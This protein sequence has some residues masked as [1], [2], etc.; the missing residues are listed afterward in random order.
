MKRT[1]K[2]TVCY[3]TL[4]LGFAHWATAEEPE[5]DNILVIGQSGALQ[6]SLQQ[7][8]DADNLMTVSTSDAIGEFPDSNA[9]ESLQRMVGLSI[10]RDQG[11]GRFVRIRGLGPDFNAV[12]YSGTRIPA[13]E[14]GSRAVALD[15][16]PSDLLESLEVS[17]TLR[18]DMDGDSLGGSINI[19]SL[20]AFDREGEFYKLGVEGGFDENQEELSPKIAATYSNMYDFNDRPDSLG[21]AISLSWE[22][23]KFGS[24]NAE[25]GGGWDFDGATPLLEEFEARDYVIT[26]ER[27]GFAVNLDWR[28][29]D[30]SE[31]YFRTLYSEF[32][33]DETRH[34]IVT[35][36]AEGT[37]EGLAIYDGEAV[38]A[39][40]SRKETQTIES[41]MVGGKKTWDN[42][43]LEYQISNNHAEEDNPDAIDTAQFSGD[44]SSL[45]F[46]NRERPLIIAGN[47]YFSPSSY[48]L[49]VIEMETTLAE[50]DETAFRI[51]IARKFNSGE[52][53]WEVKTGIKSSTREKVNAATVWEIEDL[54]DIGFSDQELNLDQFVGSTIDYS[55]GNFG[56]EILAAPLRSII[57]NVNRDDYIN[58]EDSFLEDYSI[59]EDIDAVYLQVRAE[60]GNTVI[61]G[62]VRNESTDINAGGFEYDTD[63]ET[64]TARAANNSYDNLLPSIQMRYALSDNTLL[65]AAYSQSLVRPTFEQISPAFLRDGADAEFGNPELDPLTSTNIDLAWE[66]YMGNIG[67]V[68]IAWFMKDI[69]DFI[70]ANDVAGTPGFESFDEAITFMNGETAELSGFEFN[71]MQKMDR[72]SPPW[73]NLLLTANMTLTDSEATIGSGDDARTIPLP[74]QSDETANF[75]IGYEN[76]RYSFRLSATH[77]SEYL[78]EVDDADVYESDHTQLDFIG[79]WYL[80]ENYVL[81]FKV[82]NLGDEPY[83]AYAGNKRDNFQYE[84]YGRTFQIGFSMTSF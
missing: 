12:T 46:Q 22:E 35:E 27:L 41:L 19:K 72:L 13:P 14:A 8:R 69:D 82:L 21:I 34:S 26:R 32:A 37:E 30:T 18:P 68:S 24:D 67:V 71:Y 81:S 10:E 33:D 47:D 79:K 23:R 76:N 63:S 42:W 40:K 5:M 43:N 48:E 16:V 75:A 7:Q 45:G 51:D 6:K 9:S 17:K 77:K 64:A 84:E 57:N 44:F 25:T 74:N 20:S 73:N 60:F 31:V 1:D 28:A 80:A 83:Y 50:D 4:L 56:N 39:L 61:L 49:D 55:L 36:F 66:H 15:V 3:F 65:R 53:E 70:F 2:F 78:I 62:G 11:E 52:T 29:S 59:D 58:E 38:R 54:G